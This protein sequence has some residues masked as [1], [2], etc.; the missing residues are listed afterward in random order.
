LLHQIH[1]MKPYKLLLFAAIASFLILFNSCSSTSGIS[2]E[3]LVPADINVPLTIKK[4]AVANRSLPAKGE[5][6]G[7][8][9]EGFITGE[10]I[11]GD[12]EASN[13]CVKGLVDELKASP[14]F[15]AVLVNYPQLKGTGTREWPE[16][17]TWTM[18]DSICRMYKSDALVTLETFDSDILFNSGKNLLKQTIN[19]KDTLV[20]EFFS[21]LKINVNAGWRVYDNLNKKVI[22]QNSYGDEKAW[23]KKGPTPEAVAKQLPDKRDAINSAGLYGGYQYAGR[24]SPTWANV[25][26]S[27][28]VKGKKEVGFK[29]AKKLVR[30]KKW[31]DAVII[32]T[33]L[34]KSTDPTI[35]GRANYN[36]AV[37]S[38]VSGDLDSALV[39]AKI[40]RDTYSVK[41]STSYIHIL[42]TRIADQDKLKLQ[43][44]D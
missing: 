10:S 29:N 2:M 12:K 40:A 20:N 42:N 41:R 28:Y 44:G 3:V 32:W 14:R 30:L 18:V 11:H 39:Y 36:L 19:G 21:N 43:L 7:N 8:F 9:L 34:S 15:T 23:L 16:I 1:N 25:Y 13:N 27:Y 6:L 5:G 22:D 26:R 37:A 33:N 35:A 4:V 17:L 31:D 38:E 24:I